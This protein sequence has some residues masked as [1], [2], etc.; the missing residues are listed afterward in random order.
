[1][2]F[3]HCTDGWF[4]TISKLFFRAM[5]FINHITTFQPYLFDLLKP[6]ISKKSVLLEKTLCHKISNET[7]RAVYTVFRHFKFCDRVF[8][9]KYGNNMESLD[10]DR[11]KL[12]CGASIN[13]YF[14]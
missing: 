2:N 6:Y 11:S 3:I 8:A 4:I 1:M 10:L 12:E 9:Q 5:V 7:I 14:Y 13:R